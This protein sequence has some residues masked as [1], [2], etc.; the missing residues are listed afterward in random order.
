MTLQPVLDEREIDLLPKSF[1]I[2]EW[3]RSEL[4]LPQKY[5]QYLTFD[6]IHRA[7]SIV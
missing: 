2:E 1:P 4:N 6:G 7:L 5:L 3:G